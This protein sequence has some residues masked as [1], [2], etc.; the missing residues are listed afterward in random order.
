MAIEILTPEEFASRM[1]IG[2]STLFEWI[3]KD[4]LVSEKHYFKRGRILRFVWSEEAILSLLETPE[5]PA[6]TP[7]PLTAPRGHK[8]TKKTSVNW[9]Y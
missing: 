5:R 9:N 1:K 2:R 7:P 3:A 4:I 8:A 6:E